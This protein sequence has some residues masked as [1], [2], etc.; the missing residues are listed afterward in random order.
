MH[1]YALGLLLRDVTAGAAL[2]EQFSSNA[3]GG[4][5]KPVG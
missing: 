4:H 2:E 1:C 5:S 3:A